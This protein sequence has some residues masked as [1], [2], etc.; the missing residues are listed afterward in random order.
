[1][2]EK[3]QSL[4]HSAEAEQGIIGAVLLDP[5]PAMDACELAGLTPGHFHVPAQAAMFTV[6]QAMHAARMPIDPV[7]LTQSLHDQDLLA[8]AGGAMAVSEAFSTIPTAANISFYIAIVRDKWLRRCM[9]REAQALHQR[10]HELEDDIGLLLD[11]SQ[12][13]I[14]EIGEANTA[15]DNTRHIR[16]GLME[17]VDALQESFAMRGAFRGLTTG[18]VD[19]DRMRGGYE[20]GQLVVVG[21]RPGMGKSSLMM[22]IVEHM[23]LETKES[24]VASGE[25]ADA[26][27]SYRLK[28]RWPVA[29][30]SLEMSL[31]EL[32]NRLIAQHC[33]VNLQSFVSGFISQ[34]HQ[35]QISASVTQLAETNIYV[36]PTPGLSIQDF[37][38]RSR[39]MVKRHGVRAI[40]VDY[41]QL[42][43][44]ES[45][46][47]RDN[48][49]LEIG[50]ITRGLKLTAK[51]LQVPV[52]A[53]AQLSRK[54]EERRDKRPQLSDL[55]ESGSIEQDA[56]IV[57]FIYRPKKEAE[58]E[59]EDG[60]DREKI[61]GQ[62]EGP[63]EAFLIVAKHRN[64]P[65]GELPI[66]FHKHI[67]RFT[68]KTGRAYSNNAGQRQQ[69]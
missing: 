32:S 30:F 40:F 46:R 52:I 13:A 47:A 27:S 55:R 22:N 56:D 21:A 53:F 17:A 20:P 19:F 23:A 69:N 29:V 16:E 66:L 62:W 37:R 24:M 41:L 63:E 59:S 3:F 36:D 31:L 14:L 28:A 64:G 33:G 39:R 11:K 26:N 44:S 1:M 5:E 35:S 15:R 51:D 25:I 42:M 60:E 67:T 57:K 8:Q 43:C 58:I 2:S 12:A 68:S 18:F 45:K 54:M 61:S 34:T 50:E 4:P 65:V 48:R 38:A 10:A 49:Q 6:L 7:T 9:I